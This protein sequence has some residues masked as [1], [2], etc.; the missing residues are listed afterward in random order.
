MQLAYKPFKA[1]FMKENGG[2]THALAHDW[3]SASDT[4]VQRIAARS[5]N[6][7]RLRRPSFFI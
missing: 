4:N 5:R 3:T 1:R 7:E 2:G 6:A